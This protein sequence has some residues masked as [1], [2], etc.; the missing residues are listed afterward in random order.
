MPPEKND[1][2]LYVDGRISNTIRFNMPE[3]TELADDK[4]L[5]NTEHALVIYKGVLELAITG[6]VR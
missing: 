1:E 4:D 2:L 6:L 5:L 3:T